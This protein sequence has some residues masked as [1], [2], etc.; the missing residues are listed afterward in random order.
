MVGPAPV[1]PLTAKPA[2]EHAAKKKSKKLPAKQKEVPVFKAPLPVEENDEDNET[3]LE[4]TTESAVQAAPL[5][6]LLPEQVSN[7]SN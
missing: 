5:V 2:A 7:L 3:K 4:G 6:K 1:R